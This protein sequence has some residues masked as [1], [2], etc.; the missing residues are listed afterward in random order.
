MRSR[1]ELVSPFKRTAKNHGQ[2]RGRSSRWNRLAL[3][4][5]ETRLTPA[6]PATH[7]A[8]SAPPLVAVYNTYPLTV[9]AEDASNQI[10]SDYSGT[11]DFTSTDP[12]P[13]FASGNPV[14]LTNGFGFYNFVLKTLGTQTITA[15]DPVTHITG[16][17]NDITVVP[18]ETVRFFVSAPA[19]VIPGTP[20]NF[21]VT[22]ADLVNDTTP[23]YTGTVTFSSSD[24]TAVF[25]PTSST[26][27]DGVGTFSATL[28]TAGAQVITVTDAPDGLSGSSSDV[29]VNSP[30]TITSSF[31]PTTVEVG[32]DSI[33]TITITNPNSLP[34]HNVHFSNA[35]PAGLQQITQTGGTAGTLAGTGGGHGTLNNALGTID[36][37]STVLAPG[38]SAFVT[39]KIRGVTTGAIVD[40]T[41][42]VT[43]DD[44]DAGAAASAT[45]N[46][47]P[48]AAPTLQIAFG[49]SSINVGGITTLT[50]TVTN[51]NTTVALTNIN[52]TDTLPAGLAVATPNGETN[53][54][55]G[56][57]SD[58]AGSNFVSLSGSTLAA[59]GSN[60]LTIDVIGIAPGIQDN[61]TG[62]IASDQATGATASASLTVTDASL[63]F[64]S[65]DHTTFTAL[66]AGSFQLVATGTPLPTFSLSGAPAWLSIDAS[67]QL[68]G[69]PPQDTG[70]TIVLFDIIASNGVSP[71]A[72]QPFTLTVTGVAPLFS[73]DDHTTFTALS[74]GSFQLVASGAPAPTFSLSGAP[75]W[76]SINGSN[77]LVGTPPLNTGNTIV[78][79]DVIATNGVSP[80][81]TQPFTLTVTGVAPLFS[82][83]DHT[84]F[85]ALSAGS[86]QLV[87]SGAPA[88]SFSLSGAPAWLS[89]NASN[90]LVGTPPLNTSNTIVPFTI[91]A[92]NGVSPDATQPF[93]LTVSGVAPLFS[94]DDHTT[95]TALSAGSFQLVASGTPTPTFSLS[96]AP[97][98]LS[99][100]ASNQLVGTPPQNT[101]NTNVLFDVIASNGVSPDATQP[102]TL[103]V[104]GVAPL[105]S[106]D[107]HT[108]FLAL[109]AGSFQ[110]VASGTPAPTFS[111]SGAPA[112][113]SIN[114]SNQLVGTPPLN[115][116]NTIV[117]F[118]IIASNGVSPDDM[119]SFMLTVNPP[120]VI[121]P[122]V[123]TPT[124]IAVGN[125]AATL[126]GY[127]TST[128]GGPL[129]TRGVLVARTS[130]NPHPTLHGTGVTEVDD[131]SLTTGIFADMI[132]GLTPGVGYS[133]VAFATNAGGTGYSLVSTF[134]TLHTAASGIG[135]FNSGLPGQT[136]TFTLLASDPAP[137]MQAYAF[138]FHIKWGDGA[139]SVVTGLSE[140]TVTHTYANIGTYTI[141]VSATDGRGST[142]PT[143][144]MTETIAYAAEEGNTLYVTGTGGNDT[145]GLIAPG[146]GGVGVVL[147]GMN[148]GT[149][150]PTGSIIVVSSGGADTLVGPD[151][152]PESI[153]TLAGPG[154]GTLTN[155][156]LPVAASFAG[157]TNLT[158]GAGPDTFVVAQGSSGFGAVNGGGGTNALNYGEFTTAV[159]VNLA[160]NRAT[161]F[162]SISNIGI[163]AGGSGND[164]LTG[165]S[166]PA[167][168]L[169]G[170]GNDLL[171]A[172]SGRAILV[173]GS[174][175]D[176]LMGGSADDILIGGLLAY[177]NEGTAALDTANLSAILAEWSGGDSLTGRVATLF[178]GD[179]SGPAVLNHTTIS[180][181]SGAGDLLQKGASG[182]DWF[183][184]FALDTVQGAGGSDVVTNL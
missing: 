40:T 59:G 21:T 44:A 128:G 53:N 121:A 41:S 77:Q 116:S 109:S 54:L 137:G 2:P 153:W 63:F 50:F 144:V 36:V 140:T 8:L 175:T 94:S 117:P 156:A 115:T 78:Q 112:W 22:A 55:G 3:E 71:D 165:G 25:L 52:F 35:V 181:D 99:I 17:S 103:T 107:D 5:L 69:T 127:V 177:F 98:W 16:T 170:A 167:L 37:T 148:L 30:A 134:T 135:G 133:F 74:A 143:A 23:A 72:T 92:S 154:S 164:S 66:S 101:G 51:P 65:D 34:L 62:A 6:G 28:N 70:N 110:L 152:A 142:L 90:Q 118:T 11:I 179:A 180:D 162:S 168:L 82:S 32:G 136:L 159:T 80:D 176:T 158:G 106:S 73:S 48:D 56:V 46:V 161:R 58:V 39:L 139:T 79:F 138:V 19:N 9:T 174:E 85:T 84:T 10:V 129:T 13:V 49:A 125:F 124:H 100:N 1:F 75:A 81:A 42:T 12:N 150:N 132:N 172:G 38:Q 171:R 68:V 183:F 33:L 95:F 147:N 123:T 83:D 130:V 76:L 102:F 122:T 120:L 91:I 57:V 43:S 126:G 97:A 45:L 113:L 18:G 31:S 96:G 160:T 89:I 86:F 131:P 182:N 67:N 173:G 163:V 141:S 14:T 111:L 114:G 60:L 146:G 24:G 108:T 178:N 4:Q 166:G 149:F 93:T 20:F 119:Q 64:S 47:I 88:P 145:L 15:T 87:A 104:T 155:S 29:V 7:F 27:T 61:M 105:F 151:A 157:V 184:A 26:L 169:G